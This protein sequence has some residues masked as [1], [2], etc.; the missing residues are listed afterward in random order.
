MMGRGLQEII[1][2]MGKFFSPNLM[3]FSRAIVKLVI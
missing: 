2:A 3:A 1:G